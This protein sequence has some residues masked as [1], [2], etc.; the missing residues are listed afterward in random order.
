[1]KPEI[2]FISYKFKAI[3]FI[4][5]LEVGEATASINSLE[6]AHRK[7]FETFKRQN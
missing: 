7:V 1:M 2:N 4:K 5:G 3:G 6:Q